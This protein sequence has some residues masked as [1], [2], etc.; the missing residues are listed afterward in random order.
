MTTPNQA[1]VLPTGSSPGLPAGQPTGFRYET[2][3]PTV[4]VKLPLGV[5][6][7]RLTVVDDAGMRSEPD[8]VVLTVQRVG[9]P[10]ITHI[11]PGRGRRG[12]SF[13]VLLVGE[14][15]GDATAV[16]VFRGD[17]EDPRVQVKIVSSGAA[18][19]ANR[20][21]LRVEILEYA[22]LGPRVLEV[23]TPRGIA[24]AKLD[25]KSVV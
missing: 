5:H 17:E 18:P 24:T 19:D 7:L 12:D 1:A 11:D 2:T 8:T 4:V 10:V 14:Y 22:G 23:T 15:L 9:Q 13:D 25:R 6:K 3:E 20:L 16:R 21:L